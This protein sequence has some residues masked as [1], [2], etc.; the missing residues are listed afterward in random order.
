N[1]TVDGGAAA[2]QADAAV[3]GSQDRAGGAPC[4]NSVGRSGKVQRTA[5]GGYAAL[6][7]GIVVELQGRTRLPGQVLGNGGDA[8]T[9]ERHGGVRGSRNTAR[10]GI[11]VVEGNGS[12]G[13]VGN[14]LSNV[15]GNGLVL[16]DYCGAVIYDQ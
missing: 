4:A 15:A 12:V 16:F 1:A 9:L 11:D 13:R 2:A 5:H 3:A 6:N 10:H 8:R 14:V 7:D